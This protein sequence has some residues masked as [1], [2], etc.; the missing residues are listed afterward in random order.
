MIHLF[1]LEFLT[2][3]KNCLIFFYP[4]LFVNW[5]NSNKYPAYY[6]RHVWM[7]VCCI[8]KN[9]RS[10]W[11]YSFLKTLCEHRKKKK[12]SRK[13]CCGKTLLKRTVLKIHR[14]NVLRIWFK[15]TLW[16]SN[17]EK[18]HLKTIHIQICIWHPYQRH[19]CHC[20]CRFRP[21]CRCRPR[22]RRKKLKFYAQ[23]WPCVWSHRH[24]IFIILPVKI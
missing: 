20:R 17:E 13:M 12:T 24:V 8:H 16:K 23:K 5:E 2:N 22:R 1:K 10:T 4:V 19:C 6:S 7:F 14:M 3:V 15:K 18:F 11:S 21:R 9:Q